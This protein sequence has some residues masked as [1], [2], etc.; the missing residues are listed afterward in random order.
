MAQTDREVVLNN[1]IERV[2]ELQRQ[3]HDSLTLSDLK[4]VA[5]ELG[6]SDEDMAAAD[7]AA[8][9]YQARGM[10]H[11][12]HKLWSD[13][14]EELTNAVALNPSNVEA[15]YTLAVAHKERWLADGLEADREQA[16]NYARRSL[17]LDAGHTP[18]YQLLEMLRT[19]SGPTLKTMSRTA[20]S[21][22]LTVV[23]IILIIAFIIM[24]IL[25]IW[26]ARRDNAL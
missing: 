9:D 11:I 16:I 13:A 1:Y 17:A 7:T 24:I 12:Q 14:V 18:S 6:M 22:A 4:S 5:R 8:R 21:R 26:G 3:R 15:L 2:M 23:G 10:R 20:R 25:L 19:M